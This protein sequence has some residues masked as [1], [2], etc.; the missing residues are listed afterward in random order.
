[1]RRSLESA[2]I[3]FRD[4]Y[5]RSEFPMPN[6]K[7]DEVLEQIRQHEET[8]RSVIA[9]TKDYR[10]HWSSLFVL[11]IV[12]AGLVVSQAS[13]FTIIALVP[14]GPWE[15]VAVIVTTF[16]A[17]LTIWRQISFLLFVYSDQQYLEKII[18][19]DNSSRQPGFKIPQKWDSERLMN[20][21]KKW[22][23]RSKSK[24]VDGLLISASYALVVVMERGL[25]PLVAERT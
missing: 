15:W 24:S 13:P 23:K 21:S 25:F 12:Y 2:F 20:Y 16:L 7:R 1:M 6:R 11:L 17:A 14:A 9:L 3:G 8:K 4:A 19:E 22:L 18:Q 10:L 5:L